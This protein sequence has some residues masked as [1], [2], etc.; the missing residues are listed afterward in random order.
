M[1]EVLQLFIGFLETLKNNQL[2]DILLK[3]FLKFVLMTDRIQYFFEGS[4]FDL[5]GRYIIC[6]YFDDLK[7]IRSC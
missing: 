7:H 1:V 4:I 6:V 2:F 3:F 5:H